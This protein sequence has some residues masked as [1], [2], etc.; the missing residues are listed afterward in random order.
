M[1]KVKARRTL[2]HL[3]SFFSWEESLHNSLSTSCLLFQTNR[4]TLLSHSSGNWKKCGMR[5]VKSIPRFSEMYFKRNCSSWFSPF[6][7]EVMK[8]K[9]GRLLSTSC[10]ITQRAYIQ[11][12]VSLKTF[13]GWYIY[14]WRH[15][16][17]CPWLFCLEQD[18]WVWWCD[19]LAML[20]SGFLVLLCHWPNPPYALVVFSL[21]F[22]LDTGRYRQR[23]GGCT[24]T[25]AGRHCLQ[26]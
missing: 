5:E 22:H 18:V 13:E 19:D 23:V 11:S 4:D 12:C 6:F 10:L 24:W 9:W 17:W 7:S 15:H 2:F 26:S 14:R 21:M 8:N 25:L 1:C 16:G 20:N 3:W